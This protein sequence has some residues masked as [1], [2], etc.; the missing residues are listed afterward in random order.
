[1]K[2]SIAVRLLL[3]LA[4]PTLLHADEPQKNGS[5]VW[6]NP[7]PDKVW[8]EWEPDLTEFQTQIQTLVS[9]YY[10]GCVVKY[11]DHTLTFGHRTR[12]FWIHESFLDGGWQDAREEIGPNSDGI[13][14]TIATRSGNVR[15]QLVLPVKINRHYFVDHLMAPYSPKLD[16]VLAVSL[17]YPI[18]ADPTFLSEFEALVNRFDKHVHEPFEA[19]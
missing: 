6:D 13:Y 3:L 1:M 8:R 7:V 19:D 18:D 5:S 11:E 2:R 17:R 15:G 10:E 14:C 4:F 9:R 16:G 12:K